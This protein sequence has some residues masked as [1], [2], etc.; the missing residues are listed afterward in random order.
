M[1]TLEINGIPLSNEDCKAAPMKLTKH[2][3][4]SLAE[5]DDGLICRELQLCGLCRLLLG[6]LE[7][8]DV[9]PSWNSSRGGQ[10]L[11]GVSNWGGYRL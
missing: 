2:V 1:Y 5:I 3:S 8:R 9:H 4:L 10:V 7:I 6:Q 11:T